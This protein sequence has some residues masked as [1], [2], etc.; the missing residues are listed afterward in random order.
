MTQPRILHTHTWDGTTVPD[1]LT[2]HH[3]WN[4]NQLVIRHPDGTTPIQTGWI[5]AYWS[6]G[7]CTV[8]SPRT[9]ERVYGPHGIHGQLQRAEAAL[10]RIRAALDEPARPGIRS[11]S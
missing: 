6:D 3:H 2:G 5:I 9:A 7:T 11:T 4:G 10:D 1:W 8:G